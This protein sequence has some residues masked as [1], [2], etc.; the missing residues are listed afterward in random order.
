MTH[1][2]SRLGRIAMS[3]ASL[4]ALAAALG[5]GNKWM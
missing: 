4:A 2:K 1:L 3:L 5:A